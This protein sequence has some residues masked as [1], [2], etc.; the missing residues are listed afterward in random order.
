MTMMATN[1]ML[2]VEPINVSRAIPVEDSQKGNAAATVGT[3]VPFDSVVDSGV[4]GIEAV[5]QPTPRFLSSSEVVLP[6][7]QLPFS[8]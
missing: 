2:A 8:L 4:F 6:E 7:T 5:A 3:M 1:M